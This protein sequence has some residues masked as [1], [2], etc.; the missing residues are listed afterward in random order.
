MMN[1]RPEAVQALLDYAEHT[2]SL[3]ESDTAAALIMAAGVLANGN[4][5]N[6]FTL[7]KAVIDTHQI[8]KGSDNE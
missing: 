8:M 5:D 1:N 7:I 2:L 4:P 3:S 6:V